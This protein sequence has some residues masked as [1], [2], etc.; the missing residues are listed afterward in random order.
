MT[1]GPLLGTDELFTHQIVDTF[2]TV[3]SSDRA[4]T[5][6]A[7]AQAC[8]ND[9]SLQV[10]FGI[11]KYPN[12]NVIDACAG[13]S[14]GVEQWAV[15]A[16][17]QLS[18]DREALV[19]GPI[20]YEVDQPLRTI[21]FSL[22]PNDELPVSF[23]WRFEGAVPPFL[24]NREIHRSRDGGRREA[25]LIRFHQSGVAS[26]WVEVD[27]VRTE[28][29]PTAWTSTRDRSWGV[30]Y[31]VGAPLTDIPT[32]NQLDGISMLTIWSP[33]LCQRRDGTR[34]AL[35]LY[36]Q[37]HA[38]GSFQRV[39]LQGGVEHPDGTKEHFAALVPELRFRD[40]NRRFDGGSL[41]FTMSDGSGRTIE[42]SPVSDTGFHLGSAL[43]FGLDGHWHGEWRGSS[44]L[45]GEYTENCADPT[46]AR[47]LHQLRSTVV[48]VDDPVGGGVG[49][50][51]FQTLAV[52]SDEDMGLTQE[53]SF[54]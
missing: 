49:Y 19:V 26:G 16:S 3:A 5:E 4:W 34:Y 1:I 9:G 28:I 18:S 53:A 52:G 25:D 47:R 31:Q 6:K 12:R 42:V 37:R 22:E 27:G 50:G 11:G 44:H 20:R 48:R 13:I 54:I 15:R 38:A 23:E 14:R 40:D 7:W 10:A 43:Y 51:D 45:E 2:G 33:L 8:A 46:S 21:A 35:H 36:F 32:S 29:E 24:E 39:E 41:H 17:R 30:R